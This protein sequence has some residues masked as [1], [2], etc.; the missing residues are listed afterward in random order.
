[1]IR[2]LLTSP[3]WSATLPPKQRDSRHTLLIPVPI[4]HTPHLILSSCMP[5]SL[6]GNL[7]EKWEE[8]PF[9]SHLPSFRAPELSH[10]LHPPFLSPF[11]C[12]ALRFASIA[13]A[14]LSSPTLATWQQSFLKGNPKISFVLTDSTGSAPHPHCRAF[15]YPNLLFSWLGF[16]TK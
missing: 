6:L 16:F 10:P 3:I 12:R 9:T 5:A 11:T 14:V 2:G 7:G 1:M 13:D 15:L 4:T 8:K